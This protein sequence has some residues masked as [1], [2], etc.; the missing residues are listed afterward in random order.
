MVRLEIG[1]GMRMGL[2]LDAGGGLVWKRISKW[3]WDLGMGKVEL[4]LPRL[5][6][7]GSIP[8]G[9][10]GEISSPECHQNW[11]DSPL[12]FSPPSVWSELERGEDGEQAYHCP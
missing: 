11:E 4:S 5:A 8:A 10:I 7:S 1:I 3:W 12:P 2:E 6:L 9:V